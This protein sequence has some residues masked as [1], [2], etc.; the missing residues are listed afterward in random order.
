MRILIVEDELSK[1]ENILKSIYGKFNNLTVSE[2]SS[3]RSAKQILK[4]KQEFDCIILDMSLPT[5]D[6]KKDEFGGRPQGF[7]GKEIIRQMIRE[8]IVIP[9]VVVTAYE[10]FHAKNSFD[11]TIQD[12]TLDEL[13]DQLISYSNL[14]KIEVIKYDALIDD[15]KNQLMEFLEKIDENINCR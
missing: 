10:V 2:A 15:W 4:S 12:I 9:I 3:V 6:I 1:K 13:K 7:G 11:D 14:I 5:F 8:R